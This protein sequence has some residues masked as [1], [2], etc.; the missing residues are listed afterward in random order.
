M[1]Q[2]KWTYTGTVGLRPEIGTNNDNNAI[3][4]C[5]DLSA[6]VL[7]DESTEYS[8]VIT[9]IKRVLYDKLAY[10]NDW[11]VGGYDMVVIN[12]YNLSIVRT[13]RKTKYYTYNES[14]PVITELSTCHPDDPKFYSI[15][16]KVYKRYLIEAT[17]YD[18]TLNDADIRK[19]VFFKFLGKISDDIVFKYCQDI[20]SN[21][22]GAYHI[23][24]DFD[25]FSE[26]SEE[27]ADEYTDTLSGSFHFTKIDVEV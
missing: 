6:S 7:C 12:E 26:V 15:V 21:S 2:V 10:Y 1:S 17:T 19:R 13:D 20:G 27:K 14:I 4:V 11:V 18:D 25:R 3:N 9:M 24:V 8:D 5:G 22:Y 16:H 23:A